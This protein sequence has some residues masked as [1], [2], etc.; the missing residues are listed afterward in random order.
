MLGHKYDEL[1]PGEEKAHGGNVAGASA[2]GH[3]VLAVQAVQVVGPEQQRAQQTCHQNP[4]INKI[5]N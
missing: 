1:C 2:V 3:V 4:A 5:N